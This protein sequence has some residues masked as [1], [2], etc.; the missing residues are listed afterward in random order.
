MGVV[1]ELKSRNFSLY[2]QFVA[3][4]SGVLLIVLG[5]VTIFS[6][7]VYSI[8]AIVFGVICILIEL[9]LFL[10]ICPTGPTFDKGV[11]A[12]K[13][14]WLRFMTYLIFAIVMWASMAQSSTVLAIG[15]ATT[16]VA[17]GCYLIAAI[18]NQVQV[19]STLLGGSG[20]NNPGF[21]PRYAT[22]V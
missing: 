15:A 19:T 3:L 22:Q 14:H 6:H 21:D 18:R 9:P 12:L 17:A 8:L 20:I 2:G 13:N 16:T 10:R 4:L 7:I 5:A 1:E 11:R